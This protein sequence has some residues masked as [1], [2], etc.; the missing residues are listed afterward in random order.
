M[1]VYKLQYPLMNQS[2]QPL[3]IVGGTTIY[4]VIDVPNRR[5]IDRVESVEE[6]VA[7]YDNDN[8]YFY[9]PFI[10]QI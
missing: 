9:F 2:I 3:V 10:C 5:E 4:L 8:H 7:T 6:D 1:Y